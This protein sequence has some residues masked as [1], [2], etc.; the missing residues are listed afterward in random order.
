MKLYLSARYGRKDEMADYARVLRGLGYEVVSRWHDLDH[1]DVAVPTHEQALVWGDV[2]FEDIR[3]C[4]VFVAFTEQ[5]AGVGLIP[6]ASRGG[7]HVELG[8]ALGTAAEVVVVGPLETIFH[9]RFR[10]HYGTPADF[11]EQAR[12]RRIIAD[13]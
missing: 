1:E 9:Y 4:D 12:K 7:R 5:Q 2:D 8:Y 13:F 10:V 3:A 6:G 11:F